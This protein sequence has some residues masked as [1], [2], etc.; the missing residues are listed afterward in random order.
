M[1]VPPLD[2]DWVVAHSF[3]AAAEHYA[4]IDSTNNR[5]KEAARSPIELPLLVVADS[6]TAGRGRGVNRWWTGQGSLAFSLLADPAVWR[7]DPRRHAAALSLGVANAVAESANAVLPETMRAEV[8]PPND[9]YVG[10]R[11]LAGI[12]IEG[13]AGGLLVIGIG[14]NANNTL[15]DAPAELQTTVTTMRE[16]LGRVVDPTELLLEML[17]RLE[18]ALTSAGTT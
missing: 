3:V 7:V 12:L 13:L 2:L 1:T 15:A 6:Q 18:A 10:D 16:L 4:V 14:L 11:K 9:V 17:V 5:A 8:K